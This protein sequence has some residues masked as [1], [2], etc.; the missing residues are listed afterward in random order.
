MLLPNTITV[1]TICFNNLQDVIATCQSVDMQELPP[2]EHYIIDGSSSAEIKNYLENNVQPVYRKWIC[3]PDNGIYDAI[4]KGI[5]HA[6]GNILVMLNSGDTFFDAKAIAHAA[7][8]FDNNPSL[9]WLHSKYKL[10]RGNQWVIIGKPFEKNKLYRGMRSI[11][12]QTMFVKKQLHDQYG[13]YSTSEKIAADYDFLCRIADEKFIF[14]ESPLINF[15]P[16]GI[17][18]SGYFLSLAETKKVYERHFGKSILL[19]LWQ[20]RLKVLFH[21]LHS[22][23]GN[24]LYKIKTGLK[25]E[26]L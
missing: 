17:S 21:L 25:L 13:L 4:N 3:E 10:L 12:H 7:A 16:S 5:K 2:F 6:T 19:N 8:A 20:I 22:P 9:Q 23:V 26:N 18:S 14:L 15:A 11:C 1:I 24:F